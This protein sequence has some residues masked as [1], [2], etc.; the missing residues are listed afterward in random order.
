[1]ERQSSNAG[2][3][4]QFLQESSGK[5]FLPRIWGS[6]VCLEAGR[7]GGVPGCGRK[8]HRTMGVERGFGTS[9]PVGARQQ[10]EIE[11]Y[12]FVATLDPGMLIER[13][14]GSLAG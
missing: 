12:A 4:P 10:A 5:G 14:P 1:M 13:F 3:G 6:R 11:G 7:V 8:N 9:L 2:G